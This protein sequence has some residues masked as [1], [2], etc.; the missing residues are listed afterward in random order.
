MK[1]GGTMEK[2]RLEKIKA[3]WI[4]FGNL[5]ERMELSE[6]ISGLDAELLKQ[7]LSSV[8]EELIRSAE[9]GTDQ[10]SPIPLEDEKIQGFVQPGSLKKKTGFTQSDLTGEP[11]STIRPDEVPPGQKDHF[12]KADGERFNAQFPEQTSAKKTFE[13][14]VGKSSEVIGEKFQST[15]KLVHDELAEKIHAG[16]K[17]ITSTIQSKPIINIENAIGIN[18]KFLFIKELFRNNGHLY[19][20]TVEKLNDSFSLEDAM[21]L[22]NEQF[23]WDTED[24]VVQK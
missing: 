14:K 20:N 8:Y 6:T 17:D 12:L 23:D 18:E 22:L 19:K 5:L 21:Q 10:A 24:P 11:Q 3:A 2:L 13:S 4:E 7:K 9:A 15:R 1:V 16:K